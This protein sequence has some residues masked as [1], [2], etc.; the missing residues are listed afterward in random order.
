MCALNDAAR[1][2]GRVEPLQTWTFDKR[3][4][5]VATGPDDDLLLA[6][7]DAAND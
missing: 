5:G 7:P 3:G 1:C 6:H 2:W 4:N